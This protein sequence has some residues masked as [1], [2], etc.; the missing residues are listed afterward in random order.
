MDLARCV[1]ANSEDEVEMPCSRGSELTP[2]FTAKTVSR[3]LH[4][5]QEFEGERMHLTLGAATGAISPELVRAPVVD[6]RLA[7]YAAAGITGA[8][9]KDVVASIRQGKHP[10][11]EVTNGLDDFD[12]LLNTDSPELIANRAVRF[13][14]IAAI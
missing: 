10:T 13:N 14:R 12:S 4:V 1:V 11:R 8:D 7:H 9:K 6:E 2:T 5:C 3:E